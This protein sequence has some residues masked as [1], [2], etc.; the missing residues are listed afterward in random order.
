[1][2]IAM[3]GLGHMG[4]SLFHTISRSRKEIPNMHFRLYNR[5]RERISHLSDYENCLIF[6]TP[7]ECVSGADII[8]VG[9]LSAVQE[10]MITRLIPH[11][12]ENAHLITIA[13]AIR[14]KTIEAL[15]AGPVS[16][17]MPTII[18]E[19]GYGVSLGVYGSKVTDE[20]KQTLKDILV[21]AGTFLE[22]EENQIDLA[23]QLTSC[24]PGIL[25]AVYGSMEQAFSR[26][27]ELAGLDISAILKE[28]LLGAAHYLTRDSVTFATMAE[29]VATKGGL[30]EVGVRSI[31]A[32]LPD[33]YRQIITDTEKRQN[34]RA[35]KYNS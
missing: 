2:T 12:A 3:I 25:A 19:T 22:I 8:I 11:I 23:A 20:Q 17:L 31:Q 5:N 27:A 6:R 9:V 18:S 33:Q 10:E 21:E 29:S 16:I 34:Q 30:T 13:A 35:E 32:S 4:E 1:M 28:T 15:Y 24:M 7:E 14:L 26:R